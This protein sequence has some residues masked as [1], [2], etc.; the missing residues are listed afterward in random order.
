MGT[1][2]E[3][4]IWESQRKDLSKVLEYYI[5]C[6]GVYRPNPD[7]YTKVM[8]ILEPMFSSVI[9]SDILEKLKMTDYFTAPAS[10]RYHG[11][12]ESGLLVHS[13]LV[14][15]NLLKLSIDIDLY[16]DSVKSPFIVGMLHDACKIHRYTERTDG[17]YEYDESHFIYPGHG[18]RSVAMLNHM[19]IHLTEEEMMCIRYHM[20]AY[21][22]KEWDYYDKAI[23]ENP[24][25]LWT[26]T[27]DM[28]ASKV[29]GV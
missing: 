17:S 14:T 9:G 18:D 7:A 24:N 6:D 10:T 27:A 28:Y 19:G 26:H 16:W 22:T 13:I 12:W 4:I 21:E 8:Q 23:R 11:A 3:K 15:R 29:D 1:K 5:C 25:V 2:T 20:G